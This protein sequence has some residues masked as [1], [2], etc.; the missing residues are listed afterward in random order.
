MLKRSEIQQEN[1]TFNDQYNKKLYADLN[2]EGI[3]KEMDK[4]KSLVKDR[5]KQL[6]NRLKMNKYAKD[7]LVQNHD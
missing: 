7:I 4:T 2:I 1:N 6:E 5:I 3:T